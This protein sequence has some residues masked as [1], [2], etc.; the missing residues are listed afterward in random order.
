MSN[1]KGLDIFVEYADICL[2]QDW[3][4]TNEDELLKAFAKSI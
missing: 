2:I 3:A 4:A 1:K